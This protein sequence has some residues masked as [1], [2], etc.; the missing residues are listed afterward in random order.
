MTPTAPASAASPKGAP[1]ASNA[2]TLTQ[3]AGAEG[4]DPPPVV[5]QLLSA[6]FFQ[7]FTNAPGIRTDVAASHPRL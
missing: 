6:E 4:Y 3:A 5:P 1:S 2:R 7:V